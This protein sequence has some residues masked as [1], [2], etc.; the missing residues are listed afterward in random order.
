MRALLAAALLVACASEPG[1][2]RDYTLTACPTPAELAGIV[3]NSVCDRG[4]GFSPRFVSQ[5][6]CEAEA[7]LPRD[8]TQ[9]CSHPNRDP[10]PMSSPHLFFCTYESIAQ[11]LR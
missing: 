5:N 10:C 6:A 9:R 4:V 1:A 2:G 8:S 3:G 11:A 7:G